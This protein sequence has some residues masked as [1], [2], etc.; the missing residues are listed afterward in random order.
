[1]NALITTMNRLKQ[2]MGLPESIGILGIGRA[3]PLLVFFALLVLGALA[4]LVF[5]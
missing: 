5:S 1:M 2:R 4:V 3:C